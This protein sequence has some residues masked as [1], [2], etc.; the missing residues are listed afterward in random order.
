M[1]VV[2]VYAE[3]KNQSVVEF[4]AQDGIT[5][6]EAVKRSGILEKF[7]Q[8]NLENSKLGIFSKIVEPTQVL[9][10][11]DRVEIY[12][13]ALGKPP[14]KDRATKESET[15]SEDESGKAKSAKLAAAKQRAAAAKKM[16]G[17]KDKE[18]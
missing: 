14:K 13:P 16:A 5:A 1:K 3:A 9:S 12:R 17:S 7:P 8:I 15:E 11:G 2:V 4:E 10:V 18:N 6:L